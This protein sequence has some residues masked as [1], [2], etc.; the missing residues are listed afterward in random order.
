[1]LVTHYYQVS[2]Y[3]EL[4]KAHLGLDEAARALE[5]MERRHAL[6][7]SSTSQALV[8]R[9]HLARG[10]VEAAQ[11]ISEE[12]LDRNLESV[13]AW[14][15]CGDVALARAIPTEDDEVDAFYNQVYRELLTFIMADPRTTD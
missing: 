14:G 7:T 15:L 4:A 10:D 2:V 9:I 3:D 12:L 8:A 6:R 1:L 11:R 5:I 13:M